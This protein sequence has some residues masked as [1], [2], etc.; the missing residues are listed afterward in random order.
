MVAKGRAVIRNE[1]G[2]HCRPSAH[3][4]KSVQDYSGRMRVATGR[5]G[6]ADCTS[7][8]GL[9]MLGMTCGTEVLVEVEGPEEEAQLAKLVELLE[10]EY[11]FPR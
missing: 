8:M 11:D 6:E 7:M 2:I 5:D 3:I 1:A 4:I 9:M 10:Y